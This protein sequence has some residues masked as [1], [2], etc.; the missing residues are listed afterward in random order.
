MHALILGGTGSTG[1]ALIRELRDVR[2][3]V[4]GGDSTP[5]DVSVVSRTATSLPGVASVVTGYYGDL[6]GTADFRDVLGS[7][8]ALVHLADGLSVLQ[9][10]TCTADTVLAECLIAGSL[11]LAVA[12]CDAGVPLLVHVSSIKAICDEDD[13]RLLT[14]RAASRATSLY[15][16]AKLRLE[17]LL[18][19]VVAG[20][21][22]RLVIVRNPVMYG[23]GK[24]GSMHRL[25]RLADTPVPLPLGGLA[26]RRSLLAVRNL[27]SALGAIVRAGLRAADGTFHV[28]DGPTLSTTEIVATMRDAL[29]RPR[30]LVDIGAL[31]ARAAQR[32]ALVAP[33]AR[34]LYGTL[35]LS[36]ARFRRA[37]GWRPV[38][39]TRVAL[40][41]MA[42]AHAAGRGSDDAIRAAALHRS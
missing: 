7:V 31:G 42:A 36:D 16:L 19:R 21:G 20:S 24:S 1:Q 30:R 10:P 3:D 4:G 11:R 2:G 27:A 18:A 28:H 9:R 37:F 17:Q 6:A 35:E 15:G 39:E 23:P 8:D 14:E 13:A 34:R 25:L 22:T 33:A 40:A 38:V 26:N 32:M 29:G 5:L 12:A 41:E